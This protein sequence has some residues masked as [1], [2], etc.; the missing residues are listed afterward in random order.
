MGEFDIHGSV[1]A[2]AMLVLGIASISLVSR[3]ISNG[4][5]VSSVLSPIA[6][7]GAAVGAYVLFIFLI[8]R[9]RQ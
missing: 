8:V 5:A 6:L 2:V 1:L 9:R 3:A 7:I 4:I